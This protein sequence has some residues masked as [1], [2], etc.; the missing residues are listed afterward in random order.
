MGLSIHYFLGI[1]IIEL[2]VCVL[3]IKVIFFFLN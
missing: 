2:S 3:N 1:I